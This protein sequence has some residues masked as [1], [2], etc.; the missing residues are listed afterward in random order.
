MATQ[1]SF[2]KLKEQFEK[3]SGERVTSFPGE[4]RNRQFYRP[5]RLDQ[6]E[7][8]RLWVKFS[9]KAGNDVCTFGDFSKNLKT[10]DVPTDIGFKNLYTSSENPDPADYHI[11][12]KNF[13]DKWSKITSWP[14]KHN[15]YTKLYSKTEFTPIN[16]NDVLFIPF[17]DPTNPQ[18]PLQAVEKIDATGQKKFATNSQV[19]SSFAVVRAP[20]TKENIVYIAEG[21]NSALACLKG[22]IENSGVICAGTLGNVEKVLS[23][24]RM[25]GYTVALALEK[26]G[27]DHYYH[28]KTKYDCMLVGDPDFDDIDDFYRKTNLNL[29][30]RNLRFFKERNH[31]SL[32]IDSKND[33]VCYVKSLDNV[34]TYPF[35]DKEILYCDVHN[36]QTP[37][38]K[39]IVKKFY[40]RVRYQCRLAGVVRPLSRVKYGIFPDSKNKNFYFW[41]MHRLYLV[42][43]DA[44]TG[45]A[46][47]KI[48]PLSVISNDFLLC[49]ENAKK[50]PDLSKLKPLDQKELHNLFKPLFLFKF[51]PIEYRL[52]VGWVIQSM[53]CG[54]L[55]YRTP[56]WI[57]A[58]TGNGKSHISQRLLMKLFPEKDRKTGR[59]STPKYFTR[60]YSGKAMPL[61]RDEYEPNK[62]HIYNTME[63]ME[64][65]R[66]SAT[67]RYP[68]RGIS[69]GL[70]DETIS[71]E[72]CL[73]VLF[74]SVKTPTELTA[75]DYA[76]ILFFYMGYSHHRQYEKIMSEFEKKVTPTLQYRFLLTCLLQLHKIRE[77][78][79]K[80]CGDKTIRLL[81]NHKKSSIFMLTC[82][83]NA[84]KC[85]GKELPYKTAI[86][87]IK[88]VDTHENESRL[89]KTILNLSMKKQHYS[90]LSESFMFIEALM[91][92]T[93]LED[94]KPKGIQI[95][96]GFL[97]VHEKK[98]ILFFKRLF[99]E[100]GH[101]SEA[102]QILKELK[103]D[104]KYFLG[105]VGHFLKFD[106][107]TIKED[108]FG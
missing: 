36:T 57:T 82:C 14:K 83:Y 12:R 41:D 50:W 49:K 66:A 71:F 75:P 19:V 81:T 100:N 90:N 10:K 26:S 85:F 89:L 52:L 107:T 84:L 65:I 29:L 17:I 27:R 42:K 47:V 45:T 3:W 34:K 103:N 55:P 59:N 38:E 68:S 86:S 7:S 8:S 97:Y 30:Q 99:S 61:H 37:P 101:H 64:Y 54:G 21:I 87:Y 51:K 40:F 28:L 67:E 56:I 60:H 23:F 20:K 104:G 88:K 69:Y 4:A 108:Y 11:E 46:V 95:K 96:K 15:Q 70:G 2:K 39:D 58:R 6:P 74:T 31:I 5:I 48:D 77:E 35:K 63:E 94:M 72:Y 18:C 53:L 106:W 1:N 9:R 43:K 79:F 80:A 24:F 22:G 92:N 16:K 78:F 32:G 44:K 33:V 105:Q 93:A 25:R 102:S 76:R 98:G 13:N 73:S 62:R 91:R